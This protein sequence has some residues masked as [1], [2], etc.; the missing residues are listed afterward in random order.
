MRLRHWGMDAFYGA[1]AVSLAPY[2]ATRVLLDHKTRARW[3]AYARDLPE[4]FERRA[5]R[6]SGARCVWIHGVSV[7]EVKAAAHLIRAMEERVEGL[8]VV[9]TVSTDTARRV[10]ETRYPGHRIGFYPP[11]LSWIVRDALD[12]VRPDLV[13]L[14]ESE[15]WPNFLL[16]ARER[17]IPV[18]LV[19]GHM[20]ERSCRRFV[21]AGAHARQVLEALSV[22]CVQLET[23]ARRFRTVGV[24]AS[25]IHVTGNMKLDN[26]P[27]PVETPAREDLRALLRSEGKVPLLVAGSTHPG[28]E[29]ALARMRR[30]LG[31]A[32]RP[33]RLLVAPRHPARAD[34]VAAEIERE[35]FAVRR[36]S[37][38]R[39]GDTVGVDDVFL[40]DTVG[41]LETAYGEADLVFV[42]GT[43]VPHGGQNMMEPASLGRPVVVGPSLH[44]F[45]GEV[46]LLGRVQGLRIVEDEA[47]VEAVIR[48]W[49]DRPGEAR[50]QGERAREAIEGGKGATDATMKVLGPMLDAM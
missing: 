47:A 20:S 36:R 12:A 14:V 34:V 49:L 50:A 41:E 38:L 31:E 16:S 45:R 11:D 40:L 17:D 3:R 35:G 13:V 26:I 22:V 44:N 19:N 27:L 8:E 9:V 2:A 43:L 5:P 10:A 32:G 21:R 48:A 18:A 30:R 6:H 28:E 33:F 46:D 37:R 4:R 7:G 23:Y 42:G 15:F 1:L 29:R 25:R 24:E 39:P